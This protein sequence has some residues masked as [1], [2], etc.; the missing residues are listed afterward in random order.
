MYIS[1]FSIPYHFFV[2]R[3]FYIS[4]VLTAITTS[5]SLLVIVAVSIGSTDVDQV[6]AYILQAVGG[7]I[8]GEA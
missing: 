7:G 8:L 3:P 4:V 2:G 1:Q 5:V 6:Y